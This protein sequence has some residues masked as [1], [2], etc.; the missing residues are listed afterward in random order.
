MEKMVIVLFAVIAACL[1]LFRLSKKLKT[2]SRNGACGECC[3]CCR[4]KACACS[5][6]INNLEMK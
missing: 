6:K 2:S 3:G 5:D 1:L 4:G